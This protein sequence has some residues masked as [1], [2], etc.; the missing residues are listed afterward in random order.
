MGWLQPNRGNRT[1]DAQ[2]QLPS[3]STLDPIK[4]TTE[5]IECL[6]LSSDGDK[7]HEYRIFPFVPEETLDSDLPFIP[8]SEVDRRKTLQAELWIV[9][10]NI[11][12]DCSQ[13]VNE[14]PGGTDVIE[15]F[16]G[17]DCSWQFWRFH[18]KGHMKE[19]GSALR[20]GRTENVKNR[21]KEPRRFVGLRGFGDQDDW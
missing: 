9:V 11:V 3:N 8:S 13:F 7:R 1:H 2:F 19:F 15:S 16:R 4:S 12:Y 5:Q 14:H 21:F 10:D 20:V 18:G 17:E 6:N